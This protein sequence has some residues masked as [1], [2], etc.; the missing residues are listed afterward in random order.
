MKKSV[1]RLI[2]LISVFCLACNL[3]DKSHTVS[4]DEQQAERNNILVKKIAKFNYEQLDNKNDQLKIDKLTGW[5][6]RKPIYLGNELKKIDSV[7][8][9]LV[10]N[11]KYD[12]KSSFKEADYGEKF[13][14]LYNSEYI[15][16]DQGGYEIV[17]KNKEQIPTTLSIEVRKIKNAVEF[18][19]S[20]KIGVLKIQL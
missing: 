18:K 9:N 15:G 4:R 19:D 11:L 1:N 3:D 12:V 17:F 16:T 6:E 13:I 14:F 20:E 2:L 7:R 10:F 5:I 8:F